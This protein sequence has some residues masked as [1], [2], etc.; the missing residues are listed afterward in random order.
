MQYHALILDHNAVVRPIT[1]GI[2][3][4]EWEHGV[5]VF[6]TEASSQFKLAEQVL[7]CGFYLLNRDDWNHMLSE[8]DD[9]S[10]VPN[11]NFINSYSKPDKWD[12]NREVY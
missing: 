8:L 9:P 7:D 10:N 3:D 6:I 5:R 12:T 2:T 11:N 1:D 4:L